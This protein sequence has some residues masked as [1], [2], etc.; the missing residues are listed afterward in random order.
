MAH[1]HGGLLWW[2]TRSGVAGNLFV[3]RNY[4]F[5]AQIPLNP[6]GSVLFEKDA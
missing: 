3:V 4:D 6:S 2:I 1:N 5:W